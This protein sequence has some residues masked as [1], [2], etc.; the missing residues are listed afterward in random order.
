MRATCTVLAAAVLCMASTGCVT[1]KKYN[2]LQSQYDDLS[3]QHATVQKSEAGLKVEVNELEEHVTMLRNSN[4]YLGSF[5]AD[6]LS[7]FR[8]QL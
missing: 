1:K 2:E 8:P 3:A 4:E 7:E 6:L 5:Y